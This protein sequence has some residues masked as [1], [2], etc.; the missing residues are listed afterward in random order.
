MSQSKT[1][2]QSDPYDKNIIPKLYFYFI[3]HVILS[4]IRGK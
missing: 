4:S 3:F 1:T 2:T